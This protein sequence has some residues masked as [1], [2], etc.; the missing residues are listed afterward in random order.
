MT[1]PATHAARPALRAGAGQRRVSGP[2][3]GRGAR[4]ASAR[5]ATARAAAARAPGLRG[6]LL[7]PRPAARGHPPPRRWPR[8]ARASRA[9][10]SPSTTR[11]SS[12]A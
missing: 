5:G 2:A 11:R 6:G 9:A 4:A 7:A 1:P 10:P 12:T 3:K 8:S